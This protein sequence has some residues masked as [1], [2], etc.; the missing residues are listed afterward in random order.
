MDPDRDLDACYEHVMKL[1]DE[2][3][4]VCCNFLLHFHDLV[5]LSIGVWDPILLKY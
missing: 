1:V 4:E 3:G 2:V 5:E